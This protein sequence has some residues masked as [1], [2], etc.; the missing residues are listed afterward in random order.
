MTAIHDVIARYW[1]QRGYE[2]L[3]P[4][5]WD[6]SACPPRTPPSER[7]APGDVHLRQHR[8]PV[9]V[10]QEVRTSFDWSRRLHTSDPE[11]YRWTQW[12]FL[13][14]RRRGLAY[15][16]SSPVNWCP[17]DQT[18]LANEQVVDGRC[19]RCGADVTKRELTQWYFKITEYA[20]ELL[21]CLTTWS[22][23]GRRVVTAQ[24]NWIGRSEGAHVS[25]VVEGRDEPITVY[26]TR[27][28]TIF[29]TTFMVVAVD[30]PLAAELVTD[31]AAR[32]LRGPPRGDPR[33]AEIER[34]ATDRPKTGWTWGPGDQPG[35]RSAD[36]GVGRLR[37][38][39]L[40]HGCGHG[41][42]RR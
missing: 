3:N 36:P 26:T 8:D 2:V 15:R 39:G 29:G 24:R 14:F 38:G 4:M 34:L 9:R 12:L 27:P 16:K 7:R 28:D 21:D 17:N 18:V 10:V 40:R 31:R 6:S 33:K 30:S 41:C 13:K 42:A 37:A 22:R 19:E 5:G 11:Y 25:F 35:D 23:P 1:R 20:Q 32:G